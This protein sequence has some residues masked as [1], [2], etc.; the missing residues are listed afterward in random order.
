M[1]KPGAPASES[2]SRAAAPQVLPRATY[3]LS[4]LDADPEE[5]IKGRTRLEKLAF[6]IQKR[7]IEEKKLSVTDESYRFRPL[8]YGPF[9]EEVLDDAMSLSLLGLVNIS[10][11]DEDT[12]EFSITERG[13]SAL[14][15]LQTKGLLPERVGEEVRRIRLKEGKLPLDT[16]VGQVYNAYPEYTEKSIIKSRYLR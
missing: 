15:R 4:L 5:P 13:R 8:H 2:L 1:R 3:L 7:V 14:S 12:Q 6:L 11:E 10:G 9:T 16:L